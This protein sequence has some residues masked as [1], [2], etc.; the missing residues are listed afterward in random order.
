MNWITETL[1]QT[2]QTDAPELVGYLTDKGYKTPADAIKAGYEAHKLN[3]K[4]TDEVRLAVEKDYVPSDDW[5]D[6]QWAKFTERIRPK[7]KSAYKDIIKVPDEV[8]GL[9]RQE[10]LDAMIEQ[11]HKD[12]IPPRLIKGFAQ[13]YVDGI[14]AEAKALNDEAARIKADDEKALKD[15][16]AKSGKDF[17]VFSEVAKRGQGFAAK[18]A[19]MEEA[20]FGELLSTYGL[21]T[22]PA[23]S[24]MFNAI[25]EMSNDP[26]F[27]R[28]PGTPPVTPQKSTGAL[29]VEAARNPSSAAE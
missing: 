14:A 28:G 2:A 18:A 15:E 8:S 11:W 24:K 21:E 7:D 29:M 19:G 1:G 25:G 23:F 22:H 12:G 13:Q 17:K 4:K 9:F 5:Q 20:A 26:A 10:K 27:V 3:T 16:L 6:E